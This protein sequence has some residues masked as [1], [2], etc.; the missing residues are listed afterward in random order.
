MIKESFSFSSKNTSCYF[1]AD[2]KNLE[3]LSDPARTIF[4]TDENV[5]Q[6]HQQKFAG[7]KV[8][9]LRAGEEHKVQA[10]A[11]NIIQQ[12]ISFGADRNFTIAGIGGGVITDLAGYAASVYMRG[13][14][15]GFCAYLI[16]GNG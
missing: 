10:T 11:D 8:I 3:Q 14:N 16:V 4:I 5:F 15:F 1:E 7:K 13:L 2:F 6:H 12:L 9:V